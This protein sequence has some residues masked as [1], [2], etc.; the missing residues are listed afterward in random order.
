MCIRDRYKGANDDDTIEKMQQISARECMKL[1]EL[2]DTTKKVLKKYRQC[3]LYNKSYMIID[4]YL[5]VDGCPSI[6]R[7]LQEKNSKDVVMPSNLEVI[8][9]VTDEKE[10]F[11]HVMCNPDWKMPPEDKRKVELSEQHS[12]P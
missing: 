5:N 10:Y 11:S 3:F 4:S 9:E 6:L 12:H 1:L 7:V 2:A 8:R